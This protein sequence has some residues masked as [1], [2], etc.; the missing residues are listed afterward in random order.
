MGILFE[1]PQVTT[2]VGMT[3]ADANLIKRPLPSVHSAVAKDDIEW[4]QNSQV[5]FS[6]EAS[7]RSRAA[8]NRP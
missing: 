6:G 1:K 3:F 8:G 2:V 4:L 5:L 7:S